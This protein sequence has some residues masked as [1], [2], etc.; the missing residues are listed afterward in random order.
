AS[1]GN[2]G[3]AWHARAFHNTSGTGTYG[4]ARGASDRPT[5]TPADAGFGSWH[6]G[7]CQFLFGDGAVMPIGVTTPTGSHNNKLA[8]LQLSDVADGGVLNLD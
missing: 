4:I 2:W 3:D 7:I 6:P 5:S 1:N 8:L